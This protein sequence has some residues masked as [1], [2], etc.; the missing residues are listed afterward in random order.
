MD[1]LHRFVRLGHPAAAQYCFSHNKATAKSCFR[2]VDAFSY[3]I[4][5][6]CAFAAF[7]GT[8]YV[9]LRGSSLSQYDDYRQF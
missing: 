2:Q 4:D 9:L 7:L 1:S 8:S 6:A 3:N 5:D